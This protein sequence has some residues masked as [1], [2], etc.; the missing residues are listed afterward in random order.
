MKTIDDLNF[1]VPL[2]VELYTGHSAEIGIMINNYINSSK[3]MTKK[4]FAELM[5]KTP[6]D[7]TRWVS[8]SHNF[9]ILTISLIEARTG[10]SILKNLNKNQVSKYLSGESF[11]LDSDKQVKENIRS[12]KKEIKILRDELSKT[13]SPY[14]RRLKNVKKI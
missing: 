14:A 13:E 5:S 2:E 11:L 8:G 4:K 6:S 9:T 12:L 7:V 3:D 1:E 10:M